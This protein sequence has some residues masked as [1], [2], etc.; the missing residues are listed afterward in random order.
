M[1]G[2]DKS[3]HN[4]DTSSSLLERNTVQNETIFMW[5]KTHSNIY[6]EAFLRKQLTAFN[7]FPSP[8]APPPPPK[9]ASS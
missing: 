1:T 4:D 9:K 2:L 7:H 5:K 3:Y 8:P 6:D